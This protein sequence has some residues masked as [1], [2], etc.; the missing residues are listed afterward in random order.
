MAASQEGKG[1]KSPRETVSGAA[2]R[3]LQENKVSP[4]W[5]IFRMPAFWAVL[6]LAAV[7]FLIV[8]L[9]SCGRQIETPDPDTS[10]TAASTTAA[11]AAASGTSAPAASPEPSPTSGAALPQRE[12][13]WPVPWGAMTDKGLRYGYA[14]ESGNMLIKP[15]YAAVTPFSAFGL[16]VVTDEAGHSGVIDFA[17]RLVVPM[18]P[19]YVSLLADGRISVG[20]SSGD[21]GVTGTEVYDAGG[22]LIFTTPDYLSTYHDGL[23]PTWREGARGYLDGTGR[24]AIPFDGNNLGDFC[25]GYAIVGPMA[26]EPTH[27]I[28]T[29]GNDV[30]ATV[31]AGITIYRDEA[32]KLFGYRRADGSP[33]TEAVYLE[34]E[35]FRNG[36]AIVRYNPDP[37]AFSGAYGLLGEDGAWVIEPLAG[38]IRRMENGLLLVGEP[39]RQADYLPWGYLD[40]CRTALFDASGNRMTDYKLHFVQDAGEDM[41]SVCDGAYIGFVGP[42]G[43][44]ADAWPTIKGVGSLRVENGMLVGTVDGLHTVFDMTGRRIAVDRMGYDLGDGIRLTA[45]RA[46]GGI[47]TDL[48]YPVATGMKDTVVQARINEAIQAGLGTVTV[49][50]P[51]VD[52]TTGMA[53]V[54][55]V[56]GGWSAWRVGNVLVVEQSSYWYALGAAHGMPG[57]ETMHFDMGTG[58]QIGLTDLFGQDMAQQAFSLM[59]ERVNETI[60]LEMEEVGYFVE[61]IE[62]T[63]DRPFRLTQ[64]GVVLIWGPYEIASYAAGFREFTIPWDALEGVLDKGSATVKALGVG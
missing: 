59:A 40:Y 28:D 63:P 39:L 51:E 30:T 22:K 62:V 37:E 35:P 1:G 8:T 53:Y 43:A 29:K 2:E 61:S 26:D 44:G 64:E 42:D 38:G 24:L 14:D 60:T 15:A 56:E 46:E 4:T 31:S 27:L 48:L 13:A 12:G 34:A 5:S 58:R 17:G 47:H 25:G 9:T 6:L 55:T 23:S 20:L 45:E 54:E 36:T 18:K 21:G 50:E 16:A 57:I 11:S 19:A 33:L 52:E 10:A 3:F 41:V 7:A 32:A 49:S